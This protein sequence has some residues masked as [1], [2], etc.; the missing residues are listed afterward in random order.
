MKSVW[1]IWIKQYRGRGGHLS[2]AM[3]TC[4][5]VRCGREDAA[6]VAAETEAEG[7]GEGEG[8]GCR[9][10]CWYLLTAAAV[11]VATAN[12][13][14]NAARLSYA[15]Y[16]LCMQQPRA[17]N[18]AGHMCVWA[19]VCVCVSVAITYIAGRKVG[20][21]KGEGGKQ[22]GADNNCDFGCGRNAWQN[23]L[24]LHLACVIE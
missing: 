24:K 18:Q 13:Q 11:V 6:E 16:E 9:E 21:G 8:E 5:W 20:E 15:A 23:L 10:M 17:A 14:H 19:P 22:T 1:F 2:S 12:W 7:V 3:P 4:L